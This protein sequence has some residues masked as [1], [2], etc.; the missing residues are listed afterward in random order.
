ML[1]SHRH[2]PHEKESPSELSLDFTPLIP[3]T[4]PKPAFST[5]LKVAGLSVVLSLSGPKETVAQEYMTTPDD[6]EVAVAVMGVE[7]V[8]SIEEL[9]FTIEVQ[10]AAFGDSPYVVHLGQFHTSPRGPVENILTS[11]IVEGYQQKLDNLISQLAHVGSGLIFAEGIALDQ[12][13]LRADRSLTQDKKS[14]IE[15][16]QGVTLQSFDEISAAVD[17]I[18]WFYNNQANPF[19]ANS[20]DVQSV[21]QVL[22]NIRTAVATLPTNTEVEIIEKRI[23]E[24]EISL[25]GFGSVIGTFTDVSGQDTL[26]RH[27]ISGAVEIAAT[28]DFELNTATINA[29][30]HLSE[31]SSVYQTNLYSLLDHPNMIVL[32]DR[33]KAYDRDN[34][35]AD[36]LAEKQILVDEIKALFASH[37]V[38]LRQTPLHDAYV[39]AQRDFERLQSDRDSMVFTM[40]HQYEAEYGTLGNVVVQYGNA[41][42][43]SVAIAQYNL[44]HEGFDRGLIKLH[45]PD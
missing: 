11:G 28:E 27:F 1:E 15:A 44:T 9:G 34:L 37:E 13:A 31:I 42:D 7:L 20:I 8:A 40:I 43:F 33:I 39:S 3:D 30:D 5:F 41:H 26:A 25:L 38:G 23:I 2:N 45:A 14:Q 21:E 18:Q 16:L 4:P 17:L 6:R 35:T 10:Q 36:E 32:M 24:S 29:F 12:E 19:V 22:E